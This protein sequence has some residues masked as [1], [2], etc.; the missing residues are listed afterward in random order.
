MTGCA[1]KIWSGDE[2]SPVEVR[3]KE[4]KMQNR[5]RIGVFFGVFE[6]QGT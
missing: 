5:Q 2:R 4:G 3:Q 1:G 6:G